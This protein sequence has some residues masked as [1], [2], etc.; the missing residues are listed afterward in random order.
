[1]FGINRLESD[2]ALSLPLGDEINIKPQQKS[3]AS[4]I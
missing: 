1:M 3:V 4:N 2:I